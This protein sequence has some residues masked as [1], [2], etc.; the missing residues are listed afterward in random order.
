MDAIHRVH[1]GCPNLLSAWAQSLKS[2]NL[3][4]AHALVRAFMLPPRLHPAAP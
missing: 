1:P 4:G 2:L 3:P